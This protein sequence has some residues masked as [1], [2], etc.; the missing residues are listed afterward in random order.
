MLL[1]LPQDPQAL[2]LFCFPRKLPRGAKWGSCRELLEQGWEGGAC[3]LTLRALL[4][5]G[6]GRDSGG[7]KEQPQRRPWAEPS[8]GDLLSPPGQIAQHPSQ[9]SPDNSRHRGNGSGHTLARDGELAVFFHPPVWLGWVTSRTDATLGI[10][11]TFCSVALETPL[12]P[13][14]LWVLGLTATKVPETGPT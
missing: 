12:P 7:S 2:R 6:L 8:S 14:R 3:P 10:R 1:P 4:L 13:L 11:T 9:T 5:T